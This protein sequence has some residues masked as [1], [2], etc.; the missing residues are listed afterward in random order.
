MHNQP[1]LADNFSTA[2]RL[3]YCRKALRNPELRAEAVAFIQ[4]VHVV[5]G[6]RM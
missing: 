5:G 1:L 6:Q 2:A 3:Q 4:G